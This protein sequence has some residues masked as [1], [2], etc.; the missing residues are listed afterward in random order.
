M[1][2]MRM[3]PVALS[4][5]DKRPGENHQRHQQKSAKINNDLKKGGSRGNQRPDRI[6]RV[7]TVYPCQ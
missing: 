1:V 2:M 4:A 3:S 5:K 6:L 7:D